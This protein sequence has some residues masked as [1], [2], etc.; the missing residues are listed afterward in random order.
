MTEP[1]YSEETKAGAYTV[2]DHGAG[3]LAVLFQ[4]RRM[5]RARFLGYAKSIEGAKRWVWRNEMR[6]KHGEPPTPKG[7]VAIGSLWD[8]ADQYYREC[9]A[10]AANP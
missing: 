7:L 9:E 3:M 2:E 4:S 10:K 1:I 5:K 8:L 6:L